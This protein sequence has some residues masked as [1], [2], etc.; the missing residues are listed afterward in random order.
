MEFHLKPGDYLIQKAKYVVAVLE[1]G[2]VL[3][4]DASM[5]VDDPLIEV[6]TANYLYPFM[7]DSAV[8]KML[9]N[10]D[11]LDPD[12]FEIA[13]GDRLVVFKNRYA[14]IVEVMK[15][16]EVKHMVVDHKDK[17]WFLPNIAIAHTGYLSLLTF[18]GI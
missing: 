16:D 5:I 8:F 4:N 3:L 12:I 2:M 18:P 7:V 10:R 6:I 13:V 14:Q 1:G 11:R 9:L 17:K 15:I